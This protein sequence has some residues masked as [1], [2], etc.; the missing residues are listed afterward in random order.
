[1]RFDLP[2]PYYKL[3]LY[4]LNGHSFSFCFASQTVN[5]N[6]KYPT[7]FGSYHK[8]PS[9]PAANSSSFDSSNN[10]AYLSM[11]TTAAPILDNLTDAF[12]STIINATTN[13]NTSS[14]SPQSG[15]ESSQAG[16]PCKDYVPDVFFLSFIEFLFTFIIAFTL[17]RARNSIF[18]P[19]VVSLVWCD[20]WCVKS[21][22]RLII[23]LFAVHI[24]GDDI[25]KRYVS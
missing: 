16:S 12:N 1:M 23:V 7:Y 4:I 9:C 10:S 22:Y 19:N 5:I 2:Y 18:F 25:L 11:Y 15:S 20:L 8:T 17:V 3:L 14:T 24:S 13:S 6:S 21:G